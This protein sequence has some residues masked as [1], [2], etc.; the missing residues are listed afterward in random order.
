MAVCWLSAG[1]CNLLPSFC[2][3]R[4]S[5]GRRHHQASLPTGLPK[6]TSSCKFSGVIPLSSSE[7]VYSLRGTGSMTMRP[8]S[9][10]TST[11]SSKRSLA[12]WRTAAGMRTEALLPH[13]LTTAFIVG[14]RLLVETLYLARHRFSFSR[15]SPLA[16]VF[17]LCCVHGEHTQRHSQH[18]TQVRNQAPPRQAGASLGTQLQFS[19]FRCRR[20]LRR[21]PGTYAGGNAPGRPP[22]EV[23]PLRAARRHE[24]LAAFLGHGSGVAAAEMCLRQSP[25]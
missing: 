17:V 6:S 18:T 7:R 10:R 15:H 12:A 20:L 19:D 25:R 9:S 8:D 5:I 14:H 1:T 13:F 16:T 22:G 3:G 4:A 21:R 23:R 24:V 11:E 2:R